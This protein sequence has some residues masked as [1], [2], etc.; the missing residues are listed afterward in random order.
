MKDNMNKTVYRCYLETS[1]Y[2]YAGMYREFLASLP[3]EGIYQ[4]FRNSKKKV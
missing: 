1:V 3:D 4:R 2:T